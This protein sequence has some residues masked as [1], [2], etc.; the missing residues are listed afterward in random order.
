MSK[1]NPK[2]DVNEVRTGWKEPKELRAF[3]D[4]CAVQVLDGKRNGGFL[5]EEGVDAVIEKLGEMGKVVTHSQFKNKWDNLRRQWKVWKECFGETGLGYD[6]VTG[7]IEANDEW[8]TRKVQVCPKAITYKNK[9]LPNVKSME[10]MF[11]GTIATWKNAFCP[12]SEIP[13][14]CTEGSGDSTDSKEF[15]DPQCQASTNVD[16]MEV[17]GLASSRARPVVNKGKGLA[18]GVPFFRG[19]Y[20]KPR[21]KCSVVQDMSDS[22][23]NISDVIVESRSVSSHT[24]FRTTTANEMQ[25]INDMVLSLLGVQAGDR[26]HMDA[27]FEISDDLVLAT[28]IAGCASVVAYVETY[29]TKVPMHTNIQTRYEWVQYT[30]NGNEKKCHNAFRMSS[31]VF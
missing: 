21:K 24:P 8:W 11:E 30:L 2:A 3:C 5:R 27:D 23:R 28:Y 25:A 22:L 14:E 26:L 17:E 4:F 12:S 1:E 6:P 13:K 16:A 9:P 7:F 19:I 15:V 10:I 18:S 29:M 20:K 31:H